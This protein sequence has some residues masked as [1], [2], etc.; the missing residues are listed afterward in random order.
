MDFIADQTL[1]KEKFS[2][3]EAIATEATQSLKMFLQPSLVLSG[4]PSHHIRSQDVLLGRHM[5][6][7]H[8]DAPWRE[9]AG[10]LYEVVRSLVVLASQSNLQ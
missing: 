3:L 4:N 6:K 7:L 8:T 9:K 1:E 5:K 10:T 2:E